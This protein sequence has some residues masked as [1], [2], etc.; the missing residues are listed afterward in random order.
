MTVRFDA[1][2]YARSHGRPPRG[3]GLWVFEVD[4]LQG[5]N[6]QVFEF[7]GTLIE[8]KAALSRWARQQTNQRV[9]AV[10]CP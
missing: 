6:G 7:S 3:R 8:A 1:S 10:V 4:G 9:D 5:G 2:A